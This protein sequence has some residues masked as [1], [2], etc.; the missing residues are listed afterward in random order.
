[1]TRRIMAFSLLV[2]CAATLAYTSRSYA[3]AGG[4]ILAAVLSFLPSMR[5]TLPRTR[6]NIL[7]L[8]LMLLFTLLW[9]ARPFDDRLVNGFLLFPL[10]YAIAQLLLSLMT[11]LLFYAGPTSIE[12]PLYAAS[13]LICAGNI[14]ATASQDR[15]YQAA[16]TLTAMLSVLFLL[17]CRAR[18]GRR[19]PIVW[20]AAAAAI[21]IAAAGGLAGGRFLKDNQAKLS[22]LLKPGPEGVASFDRINSLGSV[23]PLG[24]DADKVVVRVFALRSP[25]YL[26]AGAYDTYGNSRW[27]ATGSVTRAKPAPADNA[28][29]P[30]KGNVF[31]L[32][33]REDVAWN[34]L[35]VWPTG[36]DV[37]LL[38]PLEATA[39]R[40]PAD[41]VNVGQ[42]R[43][44]TAPNM[45]PGANYQAFAPSGA[46]V[47]VAASPPSD[48]LR[49]LLLKTPQDLHPE[50]LKLAAA[51][52][53]N[54]Q[55]TARKIS[56]IENYFRDNYTYVMGLQVPE[57]RD[58][59]AYFLLER[60]A[61]HCEYFATG[62]AVL[63]RLAGVPTRYVTGVVVNERNTFGDYWVARNR[64]AHA[65]VEA[66]DDQQG[67]WVTVEATPAGGV[68]ESRN[69]S[70]FAYMWDSLKFGW[71]EFK[72]AIALGGVG[73]FLEWLGKS[74]VIIAGLLFTTLP[75]LVVVVLAALLVIRR[76]LKIRSSRVK[77]RCPPDAAVCRIQSMLRR[78]DSR[79]K[80]LDPK[81]PWGRAPEGRGRGASE[82]LTQYASR[83]RHSA[84]H[85]HAAQWYDYL[86]FLRYSDRA[87]L[88]PD[89]LT[90]IE[91]A[92]LANQPPP[93]VQRNE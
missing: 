54:S 93:A 44:I 22:S 75:G 7:A 28:Y 91:T 72:N 88:S 3:F 17:S 23:D 26:R 92:L 57:G 55:S 30:G 65:W 83:I 51:L 79:M 68:P 80:K 15:V 60:P 10:A 73:G 19:R 85:E 50:I 6:Q 64:D 34:V 45:P 43:D 66:W 48:E 11:L 24:E 25:G 86:A 41:D 58:P 63:L 77:S 70:S 49:E 40:A 33:H 52:T 12:M 35:D 31:V 8:L 13:V 59:L 69:D 9:R 4:M 81:S 89:I 18:V 82:T 71:Q 87:D 46:V 37:T 27:R 38:A 62:A 42:C 67:L 39:V 47:G 2:T 56:E 21:T 36:G 78:I 14:S 1:M 16:A 29:P 76:L 20:A 53:A 32:E 61:A 84:G 74:A 5:I 90:S